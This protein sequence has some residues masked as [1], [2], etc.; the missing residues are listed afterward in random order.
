MIWGLR[1]STGFVKF[2]IIVSFTSRGSFPR[3]F[4]CFMFPAGFRLLVYFF[5]HSK[6]GKVTMPVDSPRAYEVCGTGPAVGGVCPFLLTLP[7]SSCGPV[8]IY[9]KMLY[10]CALLG[11]ALRLSLQVLL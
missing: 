2:A 5:N 7:N 8:N 4:Y 9:S 6:H 3:H 10:N 11:Q 1:Y